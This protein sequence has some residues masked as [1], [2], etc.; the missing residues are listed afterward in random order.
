V[1]D[2]VLAS[3]ARID[4]MLEASEEPMVR[5]DGGRATDFPAGNAIVTVTVFPLLGAVELPFDEEDGA[6]LQPVSPP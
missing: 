6:F 2:E 1:D 3:A 4:R 5:V